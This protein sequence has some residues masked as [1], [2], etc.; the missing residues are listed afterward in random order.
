MNAG[1]KRK[2]EDMEEAAKRMCR[3]WILS[4]ILVLGTGQ[5]YCFATTYHVSDYSSIKDAVTQLGEEVCNLA[6]NQNTTVAEDTTVPANITIWING[7]T[8]KTI[9]INSGY[10][11]RINAAVINKYYNVFLGSGKL[12]L[13]PDV[14]GSPFWTGCVCNGSTDDYAAFQK[15][16]DAYPEG[17]TINVPPPQDNPETRFYKIT[18]CLLTYNV[19]IKGEQGSQPKI[20]NA[21]TTNDLNSIVLRVGNWGGYENQRRSPYYC[22]GILRRGD[23][24]EVWPKNVYAAD[25]SGGSISAP[26]T[27]VTLASGT[28]M[29]KFSPNDIV[30]LF[31]ANDIPGSDDGSGVITDF[32]QTSAMANRIK[33]IE[34][35]KITLEH[36][37]PEDYFT[38]PSTSRIGLEL[39]GA[40]SVP[41]RVFVA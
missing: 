15:L 22:F 40:G 21:S 16:I 35:Y 29:N 31:D 14:A 24:T 3:A 23:D 6:I 7:A 41:P 1:W 25:V 33:E 9:T 12:E 37:V 34:G 2:G 18:Q 36:A 20:K 19:S 5:S 38:A 27:S 17:G 8:A 13:G 10:I 30:Y 28:D 4:I 26:T 32:Y 11:L 39:G